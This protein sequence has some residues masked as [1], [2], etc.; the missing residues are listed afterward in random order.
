MRKSRGWYKCTCGWQIQA[1]TNGALNILS[2]YVSSD[3][4]S[5]GHVAGPAVLQSRSFLLDAHKVYETQSAS[6]AV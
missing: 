1:D 4:R 3:N 5:S 2:R 6:T